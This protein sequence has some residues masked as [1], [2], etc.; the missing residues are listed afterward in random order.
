MASKTKIEGTADAWETGALGC[1]EEF[2]KLDTKL[3]NSD[4]DSAI[5]LKPISI[6]LKES[7]ILNLKIIAKIE[8]LG[9]QPMIKQLLE[10]FVDGEIKRYARERMMEK[11]KAEDGTDEEIELL[12]IA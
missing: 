6:R 10:R 11:L 2:A 8:G 1:D 5:G 9:Y 3:T 12:K 7:L 4:I